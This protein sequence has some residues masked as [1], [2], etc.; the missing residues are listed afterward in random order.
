[1]SHDSLNTLAAMSGCLDTVIAWLL[2]NML[3]SKGESPARQMALALVDPWMALPA[4]MGMALHL[5]T[6]RPEFLAM[7]LGHVTVAT[8]CRAAVW[9]RNRHHTP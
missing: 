9:Y 4:L 6:G 5:Y 7:A 8:A 3:T 2:Y 1:M